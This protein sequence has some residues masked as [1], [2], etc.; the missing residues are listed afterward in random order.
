MTTNR[1][2]PHPL[3]IHPSSRSAVQYTSL[4]TRLDPPVHITYTPQVEHPCKIGAI[5]RMRVAVPAVI[6]VRETIAR[7]TSAEPPPPYI[8]IARS[9]EKMLRGALLGIGSGNRWNWYTTP[10]TNKITA[11]SADGM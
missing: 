3:V 4:Q 9:S 1:V 7:R 2:R 5:S 11:K 10:Q 8:P 6:P